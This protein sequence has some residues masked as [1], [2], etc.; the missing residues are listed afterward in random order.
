MDSSIRE[1]FNPC[2]F[3]GEF[4]MRNNPKYGTK[5]EYSE[6]FQKYA[7]IEKIRR[8]FSIKRQKIYKHFMLQ[9]Y[10]GNFVKRHV[11][12]FIQAMDDYL[13]MEG[14]LAS[15]L[16]AASLFYQNLGDDE[17]IGFESFYSNFSKWTLQQE[18]LSYDDFAKNEDEVAREEEL[19]AFKKM[20]D[21]IL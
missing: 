10:Q 20:T 15:N 9:P 11:N 21:R 2:I 13:K 8:F 7:R 14:K 18:T 12:E 19:E 6:M 4:L 17:V 5:L 1:R 3:L 16:D